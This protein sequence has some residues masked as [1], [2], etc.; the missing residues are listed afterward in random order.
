MNRPVAGH[1][2]MMSIHSSAL[3]DT[4]VQRNAS[5]G[6]A[7]AT[8]ARAKASSVVACVST[9]PCPLNSGAKRTTEPR[10]APCSR[11]ICGW[12]S[13]VESSD[14][15]E[16]ALAGALFGRLDDCVFHAAGHVGEALGATRV[17]VDLVAFL[18]V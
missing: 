18:H 11:L 1:E 6:Q 15:V 14:F 4:K 8:S 13:K 5:G 3:R 7:A 12:L 2:L 16:D 17:G 10:G 9:T